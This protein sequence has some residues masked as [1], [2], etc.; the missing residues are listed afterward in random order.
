MSSDQAR[1]IW[2]RMPYCQVLVDRLA[3][4]TAGRQWREAPPATPEVEA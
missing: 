4:L 1:G 3:E 2:R